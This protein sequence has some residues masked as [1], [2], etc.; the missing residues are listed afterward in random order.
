MKMRTFYL[1]DE[2]NRQDLNNSKWC[3]ESFL[4]PRSTKEFFGTDE[5]FMLPAGIWLVVYTMHVEAERFE[6]LK[7]DYRKEAY[8]GSEELFFYNLSE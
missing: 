7:P 5:D 6:R 1:L 4:E 8:D 2:I 3:V